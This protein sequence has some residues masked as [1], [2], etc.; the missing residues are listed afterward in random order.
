MAQ[1]APQHSKTAPPQREEVR[2]AGRMEG[3]M[4]QHG[5]A[6]AATYKPKVTGPFPPAAWI[7]P[8]M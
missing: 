5:A 1:E 8:Q 3:D 6:E 2:S 7:H 4:G